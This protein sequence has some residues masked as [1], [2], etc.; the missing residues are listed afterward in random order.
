MTKATPGDYV[1]SSTGQVVFTVAPASGA[2]LTWTGS[3][4]WRCRFTHDIADFERFAA[5]L[6]KFNR[7]EFITVKQ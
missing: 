2:V 6:W 7:V 4:Y 5:N 1:I 3:Y